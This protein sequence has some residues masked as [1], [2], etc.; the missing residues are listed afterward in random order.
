MLHCAIWSI[1]IGLP[2]FLIPEPARLLR[3]N[4]VFV[5]SYL[6]SSCFTIGLF[7]AN[8]LWAIPRLFYQKKRVIYLLAVLL[9]FFIALFLHRIATQVFVLQSDYKYADLQSFSLGALIKSTVAFV[10]SWIVFLRR[11]IRLKEEAQAKAELASLKAQINPH[12][13]FN[14]LNGIYGQALVQSEHTADS[15]LQLSSIMRYTIEVANSEIATFDQERSY[16]EDYITLQ[17][18]RITSKTKVNYNVVGSG[19][20]AKIP[21]LLFI[22]FVE[23]AF[24]YGVSNEKESAIDITLTIDENALVVQIENDKVAK[25]LGDSDTSTGISNALKQLD[26]LYGS[27]YSCTTKDTEEKYSVTL[28]IPVK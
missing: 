10:A 5:I 9:F 24:K 25:V 20:S 21:P 3:S 1:V 4:P 2:I 23:N 28:T 16:L 27:A 7:Y 8:Y 12:F 26:I 17:K 13:L 19:T 6:L 11:I 15:I 14:T 22:N 18:M